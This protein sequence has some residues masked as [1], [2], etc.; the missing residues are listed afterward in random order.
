MD[1]G[2]GL[3]VRRP[4]AGQGKRPIDVEEL[5]RWTYR[6][7][8]ADVVLERGIGLMGPEA[9]VEGI[10]IHGGSNLSVLERIMKLG[11]FVDRSGYDMGDLHPDAEVVHRLV[12]RLDARVAGLPLGAMLVFHARG[13][14]RPDRELACAM[15]KPVPVAHWRTG[16]PSVVW[17]D[18][19][20]RHGFCPVEYEP[21]ASRILQ[22]REEWRAW[23]RGLCLVALAL[24]D[25]KLT[26]WHPLAPTVAARPWEMA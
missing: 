15:P 5:L 24:H 21:S 7:Q 1:G 14:T 4:A 19:G 8:R 6:Q 10:E 11:C 20:R 23:H 9:E 25:E 26:L 2:A 16:E 12:R 18:K 3:V 17:T 22:A 13:G